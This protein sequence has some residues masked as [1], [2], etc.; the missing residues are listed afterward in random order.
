MA[1]LRP[2]T[3]WIP[4]EAIVG[5]SPGLALAVTA[6]LT[7]EPLMIQEAASLEVGP[8]LRYWPSR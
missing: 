6:T 4:A 7:V 5:F 1:T 3:P 8:V 2:G